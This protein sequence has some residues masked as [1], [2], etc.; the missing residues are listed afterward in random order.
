[1][2]AASAFQPGSSP[3]ARG[4]PPVDKQSRTCARF[5]PACAGNTSRPPAPCRGAAVHPRVRGEHSPYSPQAKNLIGSSPRARGTR[6]CNPM[7]PALERFIPA[8]AGNTCGRFEALRPQVVHPRVRGE[9]VQRSRHS[10]RLY[11][12]S[13][14]ARGTPTTSP[15]FPSPGRFIPACA[16]NTRIRHPTAPDTSVHPR[17]RGEHLPALG[18]GPFLTGSSPRARGT[19]TTPQGFLFRGRFI[20]AC[21]GNTQWHFARKN[22][23]SVHHRV[24]GEHD[25][26]GCHGSTKGGSSPRA[27]G[28]PTEP[29]PRCLIWR[30]IPACAGNTHR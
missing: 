18:V 2:I 30:F 29:Q 26:D 24:R 11:G 14:R 15:A 21:A 7:A 5:I 13:P 28:T 27:R 8:C 12:S 16:G 20:P 6:D 19:L 4:T 3:R 22:H 25:D 1:M 23:C 17:V 10:G 9:H